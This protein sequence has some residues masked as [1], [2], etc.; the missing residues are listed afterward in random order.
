MNTN[1]ELVV[2]E[3]IFCRGNVLF[4]KDIFFALL[5]LG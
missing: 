2:P 1:N 4:V 3:G 5:N